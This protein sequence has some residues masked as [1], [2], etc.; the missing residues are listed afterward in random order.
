[1]QLVVAGASERVLGLGFWVLG[2][3][4]LG[5]GFWV[6]GFGFGIL[7]LFLFLVWAAPARS[8]PGLR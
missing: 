1:M 3:E 7:F 4:V 8:A 5:F 2:C 6:Q